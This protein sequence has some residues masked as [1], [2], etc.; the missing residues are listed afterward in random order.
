MLLFGGTFDPPHEWH[1]RIARAAR[2]AAF[3]ESGGVIIVPAAR[4]PLKATGPAAPDAARAEMAA[5]LA[6]RIGNAACWTDELDRSRLAGGASFTIDTLRRLEALRPGVPVRLLIGADQ[7]AAFH[8]WREYEQLIDV[9]EPLV[10]LRPP[11]DSAEKLRAA[12]AVSGAWNSAQVEA[13]MRRV[14]VAPLA[15]MSSTEIRAALA[16]AWRSEQWAAL[17]DRLD[18]AVLGIIRRDGL[19]RGG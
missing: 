19:Y 17:E 12:L 16:A 8:Q 5:V 2:E 7:A 13:W 9:A 14:V 15:R 1:V 18:P 6:T 11:I 3:G 10:A 4:N